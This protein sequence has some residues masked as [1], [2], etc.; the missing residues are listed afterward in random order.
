MK[1]KELLEFL[2]KL[3]DVCLAYSGGVDSSFLAYLL[4][5]SKVNFK[6]VM[7][8]NEF[9]SNDRV[10]EAIEI[11]KEIGFE[12]NLVEVKANKEMLENREDRCYLCKKIMFY[13]IS[14]FGCK[15]VDGTNAS[16]LMEYRPGIK[17]LREFGVISPLAELGITKRE[18]R[19]MAKN[20][21]LSFFDKPS[22]SCLATRIEGIITEEKLKFVEVAER[23]AN[24]ILAK[25]GIKV[26]K[27]RVKLKSGKNL[28][29]VQLQISK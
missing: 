15:I 4:K 7:V 5:I 6:A 8:V 24:K 22:D 9:I 14:K 23:V 16:D 28:F 27:L 17:A 20:L 13:E 2:S 10:R 26:K 19:E 11:A 25:S 1:L 18:V 12:L 3:E 21:G 29:T